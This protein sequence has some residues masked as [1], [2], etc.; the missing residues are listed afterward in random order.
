MQHKKTITILILGA[1]A[2]VMTFGAITY[3]AVFAATPA[4]TTSSGTT[5]SS[6]LGWGI[7]RG[8]N[9]GYTNEDL[10]SALGITTDTLTTAY[11][12]A[13]AA[14][15]KDAVSKGLIT[16]A[17]ADQLTANGSVFPFGNRWDSWLTQNGIDFNTYLADAL[18]ITVDKLKTAYQTA[19]DANID[20]AV[21]DGNLTQAQADLM[22]GQYSLYNDSTFQSSMQSAY[23]NA[24]NQAVSSGVITQAQ[25]DQLLSNNTNLFTPGMGDW[26]G[27]G[28]PHGHGGAGMNGGIPP[29]NP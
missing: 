5:T 12:D 13:Y 17:Q 23:R 27:R 25:A 29:I 24:V 11:Q 10:A 7:G 20:Q 1:L 28:G 22:K 21:T 9:G 16:Q 8:P 19:Y 3:Q 18:G 26:G 14:A 2:V 6:N 15:L 4:T